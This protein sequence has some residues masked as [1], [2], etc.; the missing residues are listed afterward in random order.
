MPPLK[1]PSNRSFSINTTPRTFRI[2]HTHN[3]LLNQPCRKAKASVLVRVLLTLYF[4]HKIGNIEDL[5]NAEYD[6]AQEAAKKNN[7]KFKWYAQ[8]KK[9]MP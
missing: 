7:E 1:A 4:N 9:K 2:T 3:N 6:Q 8:N 5:I